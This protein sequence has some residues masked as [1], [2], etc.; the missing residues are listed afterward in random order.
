MALTFSNKKKPT[1]VQLKRLY[2]FAHWAQHRELPAIRLMLKHTPLFFTAW[3]G[4]ELI[5]MARV[6]TDFSFRAVLWDVIVDPAHASRG[7]GTKL[8][9]LALKHPKLGKVENFWLAT[10]DKQSFY[11]RF[12]FKLSPKNIMVLRKGRRR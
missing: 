11:R 1:A 5:G 2:Q 3:D 6:G 9:N 7:I 10:T 12:G 4:R 8:V